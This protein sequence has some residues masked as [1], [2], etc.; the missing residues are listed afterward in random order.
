M[1]G[2]LEKENRYTNID[3]DRRIPA[4]L[5]FQIILDGTIIEEV[6]KYHRETLLALVDYVNER[7]AEHEKRQWR[8]QRKH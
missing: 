6:E 5:K 8:A 4:R 3:P 7:I 1:A 2:D